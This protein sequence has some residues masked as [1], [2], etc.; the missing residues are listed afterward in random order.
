[1]AA[2]SWRST[3]ARPRRAPSSSTGP[4]G[5]LATA[6]REITQHLPSPGH[7]EHDAQEIWDSQLA[8]AREVMAAVGVAASDIAGIGIANQRETTIVWDRAT[9][10]ARGTRGGVAEP[11]HSCPDARRSGRPATSSASGSC[12]G[13]PL[14]AY[15]SGPKIAHI[16][17]AT[18]GSASPCGGG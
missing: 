8:V 14:D 12:T 7:V 1:M 18:P 10:R 16:L 2:S 11:D 9:G 15:F 3:R 13:L 6:Q 17:D 4:V 5:P